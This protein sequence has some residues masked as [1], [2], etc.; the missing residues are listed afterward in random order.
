MS[1]N[2]SP[3]FRL[4][5]WRRGRVA[6]LVVALAALVVLLGSVPAGAAQ[7]APLPVAP[8]VSPPT[9]QIIVR[10]R[11]T[12]GPASLSAAEAAPLLDQLSAAAGVSL[13]ILRPMSGGAYVLRLPGRVEMVEAQDISR[14]LAALADVE[15]AE[16]DAIMQIVHSP[17]L[18]TGP[19]NTELT[20]NDTRFADQW[21]YRYEPGE[22]EG[23]NLLPAWNITTGAANTVV[24]V[25]D[26][27]IRS[28]A[29]LAGRTLPG[30]DFIG[31]VAVANDGNG[32]DADPADPGDWAANNQCFPGSSAEDSSWH[33]T[34]VAGTIGAAS[35]N[36]SGVAGVN[37]LAKVVPVR[38]LGRCG[39]YLSDIADGTRWAGGLAVPGVPANSNP[40]DVI[41]LS[42]GG[43]GACSATYQNALNA[44]ASAGV[45]VVV[46]AGN[47]SVN[48]S[49]FQPANCNQVITV[50][51]NDKDG[52]R[53]YYSNFGAMV[54]I[55]APGGAQAFAN[56]PNGVLSTLN[57]GLTGPGADNL[58][59]Y[60]GTSMAAPH[61]AG[62]VSLMLG[63]QPDLTPS[64][65]L[66]VLQTTARDFPAGSSC[67]PANCGPGIADAF[68]ALSALNV[69]LVAPA[70]IAPADGTTVATDTPQLAWSAVDGADAY[71]VQVSENAGFSAVIVNEPSVA[72]TTTTVTLPGD[73]DYWWRV[74]AKAGAD[75]G[76]WSEIWQF[77]VV[78]SECATPSVPAL[79][80]P[81][82]GS[83]T[84]NLRPTF[85]WS[86]LADA[87]EYEIAIGENP[88]LPDAIMVGNPTAPEFTF[89]DPLQVN[90]T[91]YWMVR[92]HNKAGDCDL[93]SAWSAPWT[94]TITEEVVPG[95][96]FAFLP[97][98]TN[99]PYVPPA[100]PLENGDFEQGAVAWTEFSSLGA[101]LILHLD[102]EEDM[103]THG[104]SWA[105][106]LGGLDG[107][108][109]E[110]TQEVTVPPDQ[111]YLAYY[112]L[113]NS[114]DGCG[115]DFA[116]VSVDGVEVQSYDVCEATS[117][118]TFGRNVIDLSSYAGE[119]VVLGF[120]MVTDGGLV[121]S[122]FVDDVSFVS[123][124]ASAEAPTGSAPTAALPVLRK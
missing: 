22:E 12:A 35:N 25:V 93:S 107:E 52:D 103:V 53:A 20:P 88:G 82:D 13:R 30:Y 79:S 85:T 87:T 29:D 34:H 95:M 91:Y 11:D 66:D 19:A 75:N 105:A 120:T 78:L 9:D 31:D 2:R 5:S 4:N 41:N 17:R 39:G 50:A 7:S 63:K 54:E 96:R 80:S 26:T 94:V 49:G 40:A 114:A 69:E 99:I 38:V 71:Q 64:E 62:L 37:W 109:S 112:Y 98:I 60:Q 92:A 42:L 86:A 14:R 124:A 56:D 28:H 1:P 118:V 58:V 84:D 123:S 77:A 104:G 45:V 44:L 48:A 21:H 32:R 111:P 68:A 8:L 24:A 6:V 89:D 15:Y 57:A 36:G 110:L 65:V 90:Q 100:D 113:L 106:W 10:F 18:P 83:E 3:L 16:P 119:T 70:L 76:P 47:S 61:V 122:F 97:L 116:G 27:G 101:P 51:A 72:G 81:P 67:T 121:S 33:G 46:A 59:Y 108:S 74:R 23:L 55:T 102:D 115:F 73:G 117:M 43:P